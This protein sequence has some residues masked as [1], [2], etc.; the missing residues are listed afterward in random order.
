VSPEE[1]RALL[2]RSR[3]L[4]FAFPSSFGNPGLEGDA[5]ERERLAEAAAALGGEEADELA[6][7]AWRLWMAAPRDIEGGRRFLEGRSGSLALYGAGLLAL[8]AGDP[9]ES[10]RL[11]ERALE[12]AH[13]PEAVALAHLG[14]SRVELEEGNAGAALTHALKAREA[15]GPPGE[16]LGQA[17]LHMHAQAV[18]LAGA[19]DQAAELF[20][21]SLA[22]NRRI[23]DEGMVEVEL[24]NLG[25][26]HLR[27]GDAEAAER[28]LSGL[29]ED[30]LAAAAL[31]YAK[32]DHYGATAWL[33]QAEG[34]LTADDRPDH[35]WLRER[36]AGA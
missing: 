1:A 27:R 34:E 15:A 16:S 18:R 35:D 26:I 4:R 11:N 3:E 29:Q 31:A 9:A 17:P 22:L 24:H 5:P 10:R 20:E 14:L 7:N 36:L 13:E 12:S 30:P 2:A 25:L 19:F 32:G 8:R 33:D 28:Y 21:Q 6:A 23:G